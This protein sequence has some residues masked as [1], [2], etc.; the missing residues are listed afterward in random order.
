M[1]PIFVGGRRILGALS[2]DP[3]TGLAAGDEYYNT[4]DNVKKTYNGS[5]WVS[6][7]SSLPSFSSVNSAISNWAYLPDVDYYTPTAE[8]SDSNWN[9]SR[10]RI[11]NGT[12][13]LEFNNYEYPAF[14]KF[15]MRSNANDTLFFQLYNFAGNA[16]GISGFQNGVND[17]NMFQMGLTFNTIPTSLLTN[18]LEATSGI[19]AGGCNYLVTDGTGSRLMGFYNGG[20]NN[21]SQAQ[22]STNREAQNAVTWN[23]APLTLVLTGDNHPTDP[24][25]TVLFVGNTQVYK[26]SNQQSAGM[27]NIYAY[28]GAG[29]PNGLDAKYSA[30][31]PEFRYG[32]ST[33]HVNIT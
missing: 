13:R 5:E 9:G 24:R 11:T 1:A 31:L 17:G 6:G 19:G 20:A 29:Y 22:G 32:T 30:A 12:G 28:L 21:N 14:G 27:T 33:S 23:D 7:S 10:F 26:W 16:A 3:T 25:R 15:A 4:T 18:S 8:T 2:A